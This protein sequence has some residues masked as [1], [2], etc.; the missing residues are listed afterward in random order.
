MDGKTG[1]SIFYHL[2]NGSDVICVCMGNDNEANLKIQL[3]NVVQDSGRVPCWIN[4]HGIPSLLRCDEVAI[5][6]K[7]HYRQ[8][9][10][11]HFC[12]SEPPIV[13]TIIL[14]AI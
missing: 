11:D 12:H 5:R 6:A 8:G 14:Q 3:T 7:G 10:V 2:A 1:S 4:N 9:P 13:L